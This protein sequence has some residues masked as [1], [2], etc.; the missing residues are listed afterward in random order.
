MY[1]R[2]GRY[3]SYGDLPQSNASYMNSSNMYAPNTNRNMNSPGSGYTR[4][5]DYGPEPFVVNIEEVTR[6]NNTFRTALWTGSHL[7]LTLMSINPGEDIGLEVHPYLDQFIRIEEG[8]GV[9]MMGR[10]RDYLDFQRNVSDGTALIIPAGRWHNLINTGRTPLKLYSVYA[11]PQHP[12]G[13]V[14]VTR[15]DAEAAESR[16][17]Y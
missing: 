3:P 14:H 8:N 11:P 1:G 9:V 12:F 5:A 13:T 7:Q 17:V 10:Q 16:H 4:F 15:A 2:E 6:Q